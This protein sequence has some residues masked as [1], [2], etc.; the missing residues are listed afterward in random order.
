MRGSI[1]A[2]IIIL[3][4]INLFVLAGCYKSATLYPSTN[5][6]LSKQVSFSKDIL[7]ILTKNCS[8]SGCHATGGQTPDLSATKAFNSLVNGGFIDVSDPQK[9]VVYMRLTGKLTP[10]MPLN[11]SS[12]PSNI[13]ELIL[14]WIT[15][16]APNN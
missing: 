13:D 1:K 8:L 6:V 3:V 14:T 9:S 11:G 10:A 2:I 12:N 16:K 15:E 5:T 4:L 7:P